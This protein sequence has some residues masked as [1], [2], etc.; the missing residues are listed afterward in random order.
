MQEPLSVDLRVRQFHTEAALHVSLIPIYLGF[1]VQ[2]Q[3]CELL[4][5]TDLQKQERDML[6]SP[7]ASQQPHSNIQRSFA[8]TFCK[9]SIL[10][11]PGGSLQADCTKICGPCPQ[12]LK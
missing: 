10:G 8:L 2:E 4:L 5:K 12:L 11:Y 7:W 6:T 9:A 1:K 3:L